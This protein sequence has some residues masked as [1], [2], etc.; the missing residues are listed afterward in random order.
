MVLKRLNFHS[1]GNGGPGMVAFS[2]NCPEQGAFS[3]MVL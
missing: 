2:Q 1:T 3:S